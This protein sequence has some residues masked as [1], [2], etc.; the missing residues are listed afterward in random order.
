MRAR[1][2]VPIAAAALVLTASTVRAQYYQ[3]DFPADDF[4]SRHA[5][6][7]EHIGTTSV[8][9]VQGMPQTEGFTL[10]R[11]H[12]TFYYLS[13]IETPGAYLLL[14]GRTRRAT[15]Y[16]PARNPRLEAAEG[17]VL[18]AEDVDLVKRISGVDEA[19]PLAQM[20]ET[21]WP[22]SN[23]PVGGGSQPSPAI[24]AEF[25]P[26]EN[27]GQSRGELVAAETSRVNDPWDGTGSRQR[28]FVEV[29]RAR[30]PRAELRD[31]NPILDQMRSIK[32]A[33]EI[34][35]VRRASQITG[36][37]LIEAMRSTEPGVAEYQLDAAAVRL[38]RQRRAARRLPVDYRERHRKHQQ[39]AF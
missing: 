2:I 15:L 23:A 28:R 16:L 6:V 10:P 25:S 7:F 13:G 32:S 1:F 4:R 17:R 34:A 26:A 14:D 39:H 22:L 20:I 29:L 3:T 21:N 5:K 37:G 19:K 11:Q 12:N 35:L 36:L 27:L 8:A 31:L 33:R 9:V 38:S 24:F 18:S 30:H